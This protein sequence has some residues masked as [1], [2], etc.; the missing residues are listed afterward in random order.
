MK[1]DLHPL[2]YYALSGD[3]QRYFEKC[4]DSSDEDYLDRYA[5]DV[6]M[7]QFKRRDRRILKRCLTLMS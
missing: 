6:D 3:A 2:E 7:S 1:I 4:Y 5:G